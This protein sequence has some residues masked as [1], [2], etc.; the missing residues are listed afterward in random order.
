MKAMNMVIEQKSIDGTRPH[1]NWQAVDFIDN[2]ITYERREVGISPGRGTLQASR[3]MLDGATLLGCACAASIILVRVSH[4]L[5]ARRWFDRKLS[6]S[7]DLALGGF[8]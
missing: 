6:L 3:L 1:I 2:P 7:T 8:N 5:P 4:K